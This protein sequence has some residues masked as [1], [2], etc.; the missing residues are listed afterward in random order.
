MPRRRRNRGDAPVDNSVYVD[1]ANPPWRRGDLGTLQV[2]TILV[3]GRLGTF[4]D[5]D[6]DE[7]ARNDAISLERR[8]V[9]TSSHIYK[10]CCMAAATCFALVWYVPMALEAVSWCVWH[11]FFFFANGCMR[12]S[13]WFLEQ[14][15]E[16][17]EPPFNIWASPNNAAMF[18]DMHRRLYSEDLIARLRA[19]EERNRRDLSRMVDEVDMRTPFPRPPP[20]RDQVDFV[21]QDHGNA[22]SFTFSAREIDNLRRLVREMGEHLEEHAEKGFVRDGAYDQLYRDLAAIRATTL[23]RER[24]PHPN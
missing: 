15:K 6:S 22:W 18:Q 20:T 19:S 10:K 23:P 14:T 9:A 17:P 13:D 4:G 7:H 8:R 1:G 21:G 12:I 24:N 16:P 2:D 3:A 5:P 11:A